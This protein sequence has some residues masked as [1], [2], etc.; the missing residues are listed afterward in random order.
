M[1]DDLT[2]A[3][4]TTILV[5]ETE[6]T[7]RVS[8]SELLRDEGYSVVEAADSSSAVIQIR[9]DQT[10]KVILADL[11]MP[12]WMTIIQQARVN[13]PNSFILGMVRYG[14]LSN[15]YQAQHLGAY[16][17]LV[18]PLSFADVHHWIQRYL[19]GNLQIKP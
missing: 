5:A 8:L 12:F 9:R 4:T 2:K 1:S 13:L 3:Q 6:T 18:K 11:E 19:T 17:H 16:T 10:I 7:A 14:A 15:A